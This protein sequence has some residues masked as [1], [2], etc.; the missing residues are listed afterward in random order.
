[1]RKVLS[2]RSGRRRPAGRCGGVVIRMIRSEHMWIPHCSA[3]RTIAKLQRPW[4]TKDFPSS[5]PRKPSGVLKLQIL[6]A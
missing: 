1:M 4:C 3:H 2:A 5:S 6:I